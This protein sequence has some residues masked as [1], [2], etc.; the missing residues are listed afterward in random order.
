MAKVTAR[1]SVNGTDLNAMM[2]QAK[3]QFGDLS[4]GTDFKITEVDLWGAQDI[5]SKQGMT[6]M[7]NATIT[8]E[9]TVE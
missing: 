3:E 6:I 5:A 2:D 8:G 9:A 4:N 1:V 7:W